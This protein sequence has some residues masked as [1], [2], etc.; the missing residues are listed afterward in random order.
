M[1]LAKGLVGALAGWRGAEGLAFCRGRGEVVYAEGV[2]LWEDGG[3]AL[4]E[5]GSVGFAVLW[6][7][8]SCHFRGRSRSRSRSWSR[9][10]RGGS[11]GA[12]GSGAGAPGRFIGYWVHLGGRIYIS[13]LMSRREGVKSSR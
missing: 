4:R 13:V 10:V 5:G 9:V 2:V 6:G 1:L 8:L 11:G 12:V 7:G 3:E